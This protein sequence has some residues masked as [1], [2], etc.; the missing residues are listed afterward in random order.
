MAHAGEK[1]RTVYKVVVGTQAK[2]AD[3]CWLCRTER[4]D[5]TLPPIAMGSLVSMSIYYTIV[6]LQ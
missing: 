5:C 3:C 1:A 6:I 4:V 2:A